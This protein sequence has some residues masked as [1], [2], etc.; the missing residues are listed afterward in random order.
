MVMSM[1]ESDAAIARLYGH[2]R[3]SP[4]D[5]SPLASRLP[6]SPANGIRFAKHQVVDIAIE[7]TQTSCG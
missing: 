7:Q 5:E 6:E 2:A 4:L 1:T 3:I